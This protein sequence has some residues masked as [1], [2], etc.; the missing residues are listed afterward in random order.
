M[1]L[2]ACRRTS[3]APRTAASGCS[4]R[5]QE[6]RPS[7]RWWSQRTAPRPMHKAHF[8]AKPSPLGCSAQSPPAGHRFVAVLSIG[9]GGI[10]ARAYLA[11]S[12]DLCGRCSVPEFNHTVFEHDHQQPWI[13]RG[14][15]QHLT[16]PLDRAGDFSAWAA[17]RWPSPRFTAELDPGQGEQR[18]RF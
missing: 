1:P 2:L 11:T 7:R 4:G 8:Q 3:S 17:D 5:L 10:T 15:T 16:V 9:S 12:L 18:L 14:E 6:D 13:A